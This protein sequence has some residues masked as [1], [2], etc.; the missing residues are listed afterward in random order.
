MD[1]AREEIGIRA[2]VVDDEELVREF[3]R[4]FLLS[5]GHDVA[6]AKNGQEALP[7]LDSFR[8]DVVISDICMPVMTGIEL[9]AEIQKLENPPPVILLTGY[10]DLQSAMDAIRKGAFDYM[11]KP[12]NSEDLVN[13]LS[14]VVRVRQLERQ[15]ETERRRAVMVSRMAAVGRL[16]A[17][18]AHEINNPTTYLRGNAQIL[19]A[20]M[21]RLEQALAGHDEGAIRVAADA[22]HEQVG[23]LLDGIEDGTDR[24]KR[25][26]NSL[27]CFADSQVFEPS[28]EGSLNT[29]IED[30]IFLLGEYAETVEIEC[31]LEADIPLVPLSRRGITQ[32]AHC[33][34][35]NAIKAVAGSEDQR[36]RITTRSLP[37]GTVCAE[38]EDAGSGVP[39]EARDQ[40]FEPFYT[41]RPVNEGTGLGLSVAFGI[42]DGDHNGSLT[43]DDSRA[44]GGARFTL[45]LPATGEKDVDGVRLKEPDEA[46][47]GA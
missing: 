7:I 5:R 10:G 22:L 44:L 27:S 32:A 8:P 6:I 9:L 34:I 1:T 28:T 41:T 14:H 29:C 43:V 20:L 2:L 45:S 38:I 16:A 40:V 30:A 18:V 39:E 37:D 26:T 31:R 13:R 36:V 33:L 25:I 47:L 15:A 19:R 35:S 11:L 23:E 12:V 4:D 24:I 46:R 21:R 42:V 17:G 3:L